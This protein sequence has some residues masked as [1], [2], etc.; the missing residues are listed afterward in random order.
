MYLRQLLHRLPVDAAQ[1]SR[2]RRHLDLGRRQGEQRAQRA[3]VLEA[4]HSVHPEQPAPL[5]GSGGRGG[6]HRERLRQARAEVRAHGRV[7]RADR[8]AA[9]LRADRHPVHPLPHG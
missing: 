7:D 2:E 1:R 8:L 3:E 9:V 4:G 6:Q 5:A